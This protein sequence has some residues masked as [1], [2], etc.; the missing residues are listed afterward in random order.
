[1]VKVLI[2]KLDPAVILPEYKTNGASGMDIV[3]FIREPIIVKPKTSSLISTGLSVAF[4]EKY[5]IQIRPR[6][7]LAA[8][9]NISVLN[10]PGTIDSDYR[11]EIKVII[12]N[13]GN[14]DFTINNGDRIAQMVLAPIVKIELEEIL[15]LPKTI[16]DMGGFGSTGK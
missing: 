10:S 14:E 5:E 2:K 7:G 8:K 1:M 6:S 4:S 11:G 3:A 12:Y 16:R 13:H 15:D 9:N